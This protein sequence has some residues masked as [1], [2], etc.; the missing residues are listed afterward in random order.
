MTVRPRVLL[1]DDDASLR[2]LVELVLE[3]LDIELVC[4]DGVAQAREALAAGLPQL[5]ITDLMMP[6][7][8]GYVLLEE[9]A[10]RHPRLPT[11]VF[12]AGI[13]PAA[14]ERLKALGV[15]RLLP[16]PSG[17]RDIEA[18]V[19]ELVF[20][21]PP[22]PPPAA[23]PSD[24]TQAAIQRYFGGD[25]TLFAAYRSGALQQFGRDLEAAQQACEADDAPA[26]RRVA[27]NLKSALRL[28]GLESAAGV[29]TELENAAEV[30]D[31]SAVGRLWPSLR[32][33][34]ERL[35]RAS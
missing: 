2:R 14:R 7:E 23:A 21:E 33:A 28:L 35:P 18:C 11:A 16:K 3:E 8:S 19:R 20:G 27:H 1:V 22:A 9:V 24:P 6:G 10:Q 4:C 5:L 30:A 12:S 29:A 17:V 32:T 31:W 26:L 34:L 15:S 25:A 13:D